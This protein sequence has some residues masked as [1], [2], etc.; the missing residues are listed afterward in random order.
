[1]YKEEMPPREIGIASFTERLNKVTPRISIEKDDT[2]NEI[3]PSNVPPLADPLC[4]IIRNSIQGTPVTRSQNIFDRAIFQLDGGADYP[5]EVYQDARGIK[6]EDDT[7]PQSYGLQLNRSS[8]NPIEHEEDAMFSDINAG[9]EVEESKNTFED[10]GPLKFT[11][12]QLVEPHGLTEDTVSWQMRDASWQT[13]DASWQTFDAHPE[14]SKGVPQSDQFVES[15]NTQPKINIKYPLPVSQTVQEEQSMVKEEST[16]L[17]PGGLQPKFISTNLASLRPADDTQAKNEGDKSATIES[18][19]AIDSVVVKIEDEALAAL[20]AVVSSTDISNTVESKYDGLPKMK[21]QEGPIGMPLTTNSGEEVL[22]VPI[23]DSEINTRFSLSSHISQPTSTPTGFSEAKV[24][25][26]L[27]QSSPKI[28]PVPEA[29]SECPP[30][31]QPFNQSQM[32]LDAP[33]ILSSGVQNAQMVPDSN[34]SALSAASSPEETLFTGN[35]LLPSHVPPSKPAVQSPTESQLTSPPQTPIKAQSVVEEVQQATIIKQTLVVK[36]EVLDAYHFL[37]QSYYNIPP[38]ISTTDVHQAVEQAGLLV[39]VAALYQSLPSVRPH[40]CYS[41]LSH[42]RDLHSAILQNPPHFLLLS[43]KLR[44]APIFREAIIHI[45]G[46]APLWPWPVSRDV[47]PAK[48]LHLIETKIVDFRSAK[49]AVNTELFT[50]CLAKGNARI[51]ITKIDPGTLDTWVVVQM[52]HDWF[53]GA[54][55]E[56]NTMREKQGKV[57]EGNMYRLIARGGDSYLPIEDV[58]RVLRPFKAQPGSSEWGN[59][60]RK[61][62][63]EDLRMMKEY[64]AKAVK[65]LVI[66]RAMINV[67]GGED[68]RDVGHLTCVKVEENELP[69]VGGSENGE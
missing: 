53:C 10:L 19:D 52:W 59:W 28:D 58:L 12:E 34:A 16:E 2:T 22:D 7:V 9:Q 37:F 18:F 49:N 46:Q 56:C 67:M 54:V 27:I 26:K 20:A 23:T 51:T 44:C 24:E 42:G 3:K 57:V 30:T 45:V 1:M 5:E 36:S 69:W 41:L 29:A 17:Q 68:E 48:V 15:S 25:E 8:L 38:A 66:N 33:A 6:V 35:A 64:A 11:T 4:S 65:G 47:I 60:Q 55:R 61:E 14:M 62:V 63:E 43:L 13:C 32:S 50:S 21:L 39:K 40:I 31:E